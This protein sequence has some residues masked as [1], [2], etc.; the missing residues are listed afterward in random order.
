MVV[1]FAFIFIERIAKFAITM[2]APRRTDE[3]IDNQYNTGTLSRAAM[4][5][6]LRQPV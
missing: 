4:G 1:A 3:S 5:G 6:A 2:P